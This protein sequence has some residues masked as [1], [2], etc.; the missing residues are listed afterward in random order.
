MPTTTVKMRQYRLERLL[1]VSATFVRETSFIFTPKIPGTTTFGFRGVCF[2]GSELV[3]STTRS[4]ANISSPC[5]VFVDPRTL[6]PRKQLDLVISGVFFD[7][8]DVCWMGGNQYGVMTADN[9]GGAPTFRRDL[10]IVDGAS[11]YADVM[12]TGIVSTTARSI[13]W[14]GHDFLISSVSG[15]LGE[16]VDQVSVNGITRRQSPLI[17]AGF[18][19]PGI[20]LVRDREMRAGERLLAK[21]DPTLFATR[22]WSYY[23]RGSGNPRFLRQVVGPADN[24]TEQ[25]PIAMSPSYFWEFDSSN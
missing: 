18:V 12:A 21:A 2:N 19:G 3:F 11:G 16:L 25:Q 22:S 13:D 24:P 7:A 1:G 4:L 8:M 9:G 17:T 6:T 14:T 20:A 23:T 10:H 15:G 5:L